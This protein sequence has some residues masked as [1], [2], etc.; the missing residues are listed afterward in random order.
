MVPVFA[1]TC[2]IVTLASLAVTFLLSCQSWEHRRRVRCWLSAPRP[3]RKGFRVSLIAPCKGVDLELAENLQALFHQDYLNYEIVFVTESADDPASATIQSLIADNSRIRAQLIFAGVAE[4]GCQKVHNLKA[5]LAAADSSAEAFAFVDSDVCPWPEWLGDLVHRLDDQAVGA[6]TGYRWFAPQRFS[7]PNAVA[8]SVNATAASLYTPKS[9]QPIWGGSWAIRREVFDKSR[10]AEHWEDRLTDDLVATNAV[11]AAGFR[12]V[13]EPRCMIPSPIDFDWRR[14]FAF[15]RRQY[16]IGRLYTTC[17]WQLALGATTLTVVGF[18]GCFAAAAFGWMTRAPW[19]W[20]PTAACAAWYALN[21]ARA[22]IRRQLA[23]LYLPQAK[24]RA[25]NLFDALATPLSALVNWAAIVSS[26]GVRRMVWRGIEYRI[27]SD[28]RS[29][30]VRP[31]AGRIGDA[32]GCATPLV[33]D[34][35][36]VVQLLPME[37]GSPAATTNHRSK[38]A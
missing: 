25:M 11:R 19:A 22:V 23:V 26:I 35:R 10:V 32:A 15:L 6:V 7:I 14:M 29:R 33:V 34:E 38:A 9:F 21:L 20:A 28:G 13:F 5:A 37:I 16:L 2:A 12:V 17:W 36:G 1:I 18:W 30:V 31:V 4:R 3:P 24:L 8:Y 27:E